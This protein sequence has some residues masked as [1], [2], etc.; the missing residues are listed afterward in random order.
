MKIGV[1]VLVY[2]QTSDYVRNICI[3]SCLFTSSRSVIVVNIFLVHLLVNCKLIA[4]T[5]KYSVIL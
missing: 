5:F 3:D 2:M 1:K 4:H